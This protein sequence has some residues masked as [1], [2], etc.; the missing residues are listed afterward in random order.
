MLDFM[1]CSHSWTHLVARSN[2][3]IGPVAVIIEYS[4]A[5]VDLE[6]GS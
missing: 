5:I 1:N 4:T 6:L 3:S 2:A